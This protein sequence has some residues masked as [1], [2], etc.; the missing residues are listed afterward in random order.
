MGRDG[1]RHLDEQAK[2]IGASS[3]RSAW[4]QDWVIGHERWHDARLS[5]CEDLRISVVFPRRLPRSDIQLGIRRP[6]IPL[7]SSS[8]GVPQLAPRDT[9][10]VFDKI[11]MS[12]FEG[13]PLD[14]ALRDCG[15]RV[16]VIVG[17]AL[18]IGIEPTIRQ[19]ADLGYIS[20]VVE[21][22]CG[23]G[24]DDAGKRAIASLRYMNDAL[25]TNVSEITALL[26]GHAT[27]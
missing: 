13:T 12:A 16:F 27:T 9:E 10:A 25:F 21:D 1:F 14:T 24:D 20:V 19:G 5:A 11:G 17:V 7:M 4:A 26:R 6:M 23:A 3:R 15:I 8:S 2:L 18:E 22:A